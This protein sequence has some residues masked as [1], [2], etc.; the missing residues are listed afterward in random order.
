MMTIGG[1]ERK[2]KMKTWREARDGD[3]MMAEF[4]VMSI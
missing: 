2:V 1:L 4:L 3:G